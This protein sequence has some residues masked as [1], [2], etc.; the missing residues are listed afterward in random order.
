MF[1]NELS[2]KFF[3]VL[4]RIS[5][6]LQMKS[7]GK[8]TSENGLT[9]VLQWLADAPLFIDADQVGRFHDAVVRPKYEEGTTTLEIRI[10]NSATIAGRL[11][12]DASLKPNALLQSLATVL[13]WVKAELSLH[14]E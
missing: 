11:G 6:R 12:M 13:P 2:K 9:D 14:G 3:S 5:G 4:A 10:E 1:L 8:A 7:E